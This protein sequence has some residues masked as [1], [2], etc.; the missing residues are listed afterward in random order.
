VNITKEVGQ[1]LI[2]IASNIGLIIFYMIFLFFE[3]AVFEKKMEAAFPKKI[4]RRQATALF[5]KI[6]R[7]ISTYFRLK[8][9]ISL[10]VGFFSYIVLK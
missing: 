5:S 7:D 10:V 3:Y 4:H 6:T 1:T 9:A 8:S 2:G